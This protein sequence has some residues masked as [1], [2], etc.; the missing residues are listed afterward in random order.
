MKTASL[1]KLMIFAGLAVFLSACGEP[2]PVEAQIR[3]WVAAAEKSAE[4]R[5]LGELKDL[6]ADDYADANG[7]AR[8]DVIN[9]MRLYLLRNKSINML[10]RIRDIEVLAED[11]VHRGKR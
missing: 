5:D 3:A 9:L 6:V 1:R 8:Q 7:H 11:R 2:P 4:A 10:T